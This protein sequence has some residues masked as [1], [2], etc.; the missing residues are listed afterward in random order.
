MLPFYKLAWIL[1][2]S[3]LPMCLACVTNCLFTAGGPIY[4]FINLWWSHPRNRITNYG[5]KNPFPCGCHY[6]HN[7]ALNLSTTATGCCDS[8]QQAHKDGM[9]TKGSQVCF[10]KGPLSTRRKPCT[11]PI[12]SDACSVAHHQFMQMSSC[13]IGLPGHCTCITL[14]EWGHNPNLSWNSKANGPAPNP[15]HVNRLVAPPG[16]KGTFLVLVSLL[17]L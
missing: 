1:H 2:F 10:S 16:G 15:V 11:T 17:W 7:V 14:R 13:Y 9:L 3:W 4:V 8:A 12:H 6:G 5:E